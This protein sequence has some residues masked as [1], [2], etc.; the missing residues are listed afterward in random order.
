M[1]LKT[2][3]T[4]PKATRTIPKETGRDDEADGQGDGVRSRTM[5]MLTARTMMIELSSRHSCLLWEVKLVRV[6]SLPWEERK[7]CDDGVQESGKGEEVPI[8]FM[9]SITGYFSHTSPLSIL[10]PIQ[11]P[12]FHPN[13]E[14]TLFAVC[15][16]A[17]SS[18]SYL[19][20]GSG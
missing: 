15:L 3:R 5:E 19:Q 16:D 1:T 4:I 13:L 12:R 7:V 17:A 11:T 2:T 10:L 8:L 9:R 14:D 18:S 20:A 6:P